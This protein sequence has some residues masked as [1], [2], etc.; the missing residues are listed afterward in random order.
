MIEQDG[1]G[2]ILRCDLNSP[3]DLDEPADLHAIL[4]A[5]LVDGLANEVQHLLLS[6]S[7]KS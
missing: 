7:F 5:V 6:R 3:H 4:G 1:V 2:V